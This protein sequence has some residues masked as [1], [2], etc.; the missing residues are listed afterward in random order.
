MQGV[1]LGEFVADLRRRVAA[2]ELWPY[3]E[4]GDSGDSAGVAAT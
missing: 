4:D 2:R 3:A 1:P